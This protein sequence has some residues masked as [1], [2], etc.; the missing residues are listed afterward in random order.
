MIHLQLKPEEETRLIAL[1]DQFNKELEDRS[2]PPFPKATTLSA[3]KTELNAALQAQ[4][5]FEAIW[6]RSQ[7]K[8][9]T[10]YLHHE[11]TDIRN[12]PWQ[13]ATAERPLLTVAKTPVGNLAAHTPSVGFPLK[14]LVMVASPEGV[15]RLAYED[16]ELQ[17]LR[18]FS[19]LMAQGL[20]EVHFT[21][22]GSLE[23]LEEKLSENRYHILHFSGHGS[24]HEGK[25]ILAL[26][27]PMTGR[28]KAATAEAF[29]QVLARVSQKQHRPDLVVL[30]ACQT[31]QGV[32]A[33]NLAGVA[34]TLL[35]GGTSAV[36]AMSA[37][38]SDIC[39]TLF[40]AKLYA[41]LSN[42]FPLPAAFQHALAAVREYEQ[43]LDLAKHGLAP[44][45]W[46]IPQ[47]LL[48][49]KVGELVD[50]N[51]PKT[52]L[53]LQQNADIIKGEQA[54]VH[55]RVRPKNYVFVGRR[56]EKRIA[57][58]QLQAGK[59]ILLRGQGGVG[60][61][62]LA[63]HLAI[64]LLASNPRHK[65]FTFSEKTPVAQSLLDQMQNYLTKEKKQFSIVSELA[66]IPK[67]TDKFY[68]LLEKISAHCDPVFIFDNMET[69]QRFDAEQAAWL[70]YREKHE[71]VFEVM[72]ILDQQ[73]PFPLIIT[74]RYPLAEFPELEICNMN[75][76][77]FADFF[78]KCHQLNIKDFAQKA[79]SEAFLSGA[80]KRS[81]DE[82]PPTFEDIAKLLHKT[83][84]GNYRALEF[85]D[86]LYTQKGADIAH[87]LRKLS[88]FESTL[89]EDD[90]KEGVLTQMSE[91]L[92]FEE[93]L[94]Y[95]NTREKDTLYVLAQYNIP[96]LPMAV[97]MQRKA[98]DRSKDLRKATQL[99][100]VEAQTGLDGRERFYVMPLVRDL[101]KRQEMDLVFD[102][103]VAGDYHWYVAREGA[104]EN[105]IIDSIEAF[106]RYHTTQTIQKI[107]VVGQVLCT[108]HYLIEQF[109]LSESY[110][111]RTEN[112]AGEET[113]GEVLNCLGLIYQLRGKSELALSYFEKSLKYSKGVDAQG[114]GRVLTNI[115]QIYD[116]KG[117][118]DLALSYLEKSLKINETV[119][120]IKDHAN[121][122]NNIGQIYQ[123]KDDYAKALFYLKQSLVIS[124]KIN[125][126]RGEGI[127]LSNI[128]QVYDL[129]NNY[130]EAL[131]YLEKS[132]KINQSVGNRM[133]ESRSLN[134]IGNILGNKG[135]YDNALTY[136]EKSLAISQE[137][138]DRIGESNTLGNIGKIYDSK[139]DY[140]KGLYYSK[141]S[142]R[143]SKETGN[144]GGQSTA[145]NNIGKIYVSTGNYDEALFYF[146][147]S[148]KIG[149]KRTS[150]SSHAAT[151]MNIGVTLCQKKLFE[152]AMPHLFTAYQIFNETD[153]SPCK[154]NIEKA[155]DLIIYKIGESRFKKILDNI[156]NQKINHV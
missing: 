84:G 6:Q 68:H 69:F 85:F 94:G 151:L 105:E 39:A 53:N 124:Q 13:A 129:Q 116:R 97:G 41:E 25:G 37:S 108:F 29:N 8:A 1:A 18:A 101:L 140:D 93:L 100:L 34:D 150:L 90:I 78:R 73:T 91:N 131:H 156:I 45:Q 3:L 27:D 111:L 30:S 104:S 113:C 83:F 66:T 98:D 63:E 7:T 57:L 71:D 32:E 20:A 59:S 95:L 54:L 15:T 19:P 86:E 138:E 40:A 42:G 65:V 82:R 52:V 120:D 51:A 122:L 2:T 115:S 77:P 74:G 87:T 149:H 23:N 75:T 134:N 44:A 43:T 12:L 147:E 118:F 36:I 152:E 14:V 143:I 67:Q 35:E 148:L 130:D 103:K 146:N 24:Y 127:T 109:R 123:K 33:G 88:D 48:H 22:D 60:K 154:E 126:L 106:E 21:D 62:A 10:L 136:F 64:R 121:I 145:L 16:E 56:R 70:W 153:N 112:I 132:L 49:Q 125:D 61:T 139:G 89:Q 38:V 117:N 107:N 72:S 142:L 141:E 76:V 135:D 128:G 92:I 99:T 11:R 155:V 55:L 119:G 5:D 31:A 50:K 102:E 96:V 133:G 17:L 114:E 58:R 80:L 28:M 79:H 46:L 144:Y 9:E 4:T 81:G 47:L 26:E 110:G 137:F